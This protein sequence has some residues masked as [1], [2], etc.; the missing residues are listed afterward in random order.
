M[1]ELSITYDKISGRIEARL[2]VEIKARE[3]TGTQKVAVDLGETILMACA[4]GDGT[5]AL[6]SGRLIKAVRRY[7][8]KVRADLKQNS[9]RWRETAHRE[10]KQVE[11][12]LYAAT[13]HFIAECVR[14]GVKEIAIGNLDGIRESIDYG[15]RL[16]QR[17]HAW[18][19]RKLVNML[20]YK[21]A[22]TGIVVRDDASKTCHGCGVVK[23]SNRKQRG[24]YACSCG[25]RVQADINGA[26]NIYERAYK[27]SSVR[28]SSG[29]V[30][31]PAAV[32]FLLGWHGVVE[33]KRKDKTLRA[34][35]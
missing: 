33:P 3:N 21:G 14:R 34:S 1:R 32:S 2:V 16:N 19:Y 23:A 4:F 30:A 26:L 15:D 31:R 27:V 13:S 17:L 24:L 28:G 7:W 8:Q 10:K 12:L 18:P 6:Y 11:H 25:W 9:R 29:R 20:K 35:A 22:L 5:V